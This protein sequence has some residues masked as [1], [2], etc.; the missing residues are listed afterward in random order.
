MPTRAGEMLFRG[1]RDGLPPV[2]HSHKK[3]AKNWPVRRP[4]THYFHFPTDGRA[5]GALNIASRAL[6]REGFK[7]AARQ[8]FRG[9]KS[10]DGGG[11]GR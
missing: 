2:R 1:P 6:A 9:S 5:A 3:T 10:P 8:A 4:D 11:G 7:Q